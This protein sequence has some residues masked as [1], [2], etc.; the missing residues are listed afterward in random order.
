MI[1]PDQMET[2]RDEWDR[3]RFLHQNFLEKRHEE[4]SKAGEHLWGAINCLASALYRLQNGSG[5]SQHRDV[6]RFLDELVQSEPE[7]EERHR[8]APEDLHGNYYHDNLTESR[9]ER[10]IENAAY[11]YD[12]LDKKVGE[13]LQADRRE[14]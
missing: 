8:D 2:A 12:F 11:M 6:M 4:P 13:R 3:A 14:N 7:L 5:I 9:L 10:E 1:R